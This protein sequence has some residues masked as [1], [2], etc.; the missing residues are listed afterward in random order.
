MMGDGTGLKA[1]L[2]VKLYAGGVLVAESEDPVLWQQVMASIT[3]SVASVTGQVA[4]GGVP[5]A[6][7]LDGGGGDAVSK[8]ATDLGVTREALIGA[9]DPQDHTPFIHI[10]VR[11]WEAFRKN[12]AKRGATAVPK[13]T[14]AATAMVLWFQ[15]AG[16]GNPTQAQ[17]QEALNAIND[18]EANPSR[19]IHN[20]DWLQSRQ[21]GVTLNPA[22][23][24]KGRRLVKAFCEKTGWDTS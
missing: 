12:F 13:I 7:D 4:G 15:H 9:L 18:A 1:E 14:M 16:F 23:A 8:F 21:D 17:A 5:P 22:Q 20:C 6:L 10:D 19:A 11:T 24:S 2:V 3:S